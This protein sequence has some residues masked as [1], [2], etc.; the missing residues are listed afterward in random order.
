MERTDRLYIVEEVRTARRGVGSVLQRYS[1]VFTPHPIAP[2]QFVPLHNSLLSRSALS[3]QA[4]ILSIYF[5]RSP[6]LSS[7]HPKRLQKEKIRRRG[8]W[9]KTHETRGS[10]LHA[11]PPPLFMLC[12]RFRRLRAIIVQVKQLVIVIVS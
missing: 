2:H 11:E 6:Q 3:I 10:P 4:S 7:Y 1:L 9:E 8:K 5:Q 12:S